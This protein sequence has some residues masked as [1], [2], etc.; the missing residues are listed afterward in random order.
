MKILLINV[1]RGYPE[2]KIAN[3]NL[4]EMYLTNKTTFVS[5]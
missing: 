4:H 5:N 3:N 1:R 2:N